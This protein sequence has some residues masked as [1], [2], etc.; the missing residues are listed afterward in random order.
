MFFTQNV[1][2][3]FYFSF[4]VCF[5]SLFP[6]NPPTS[7]PPS[8]LL[9]QYRVILH[10]KPFPKNLIGSTFEYS[11]FVCR[12]LYFAAVVRA[13]FFKFLHS[14]L[15]T[16]LLFFLLINAV[17]LFATVRFEFVSVPIMFSLISWLIIRQRCHSLPSTIS[18]HLS[19]Q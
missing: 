11:P 7:F 8:N 4:C 9:P 1:V 10:Q 18:F 14:T 19:T 3:S 6:Y 16:C 12:V 5:I 17:K 13:I 2:F 15:P